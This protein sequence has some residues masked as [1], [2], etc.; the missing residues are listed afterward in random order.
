MPIGAKVKT[1]NLMA[2][3]AFKQSD[4][5]HVKEEEENLGFIEHP[6]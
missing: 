3:P 2:P 1:R 6:N 5:S 4:L